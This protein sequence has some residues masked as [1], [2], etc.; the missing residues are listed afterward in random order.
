MGVV[1]KNAVGSRPN[2]PLFFHNRGVPIRTWTK[3]DNFP[4][5]N[6]CE[7][8]QHIFEQVV[9]QPL[10][11]PSSQKCPVCLV[12]MLVALPTVTLL[13]KIVSPAQLVVKGSRPAGPRGPILANQ[14]LCPIIGYHAGRLQHK[15]P[16]DGFQ[17]T[18]QHDMV[19]EGR[20][21]TVQTPIGQMK[22]VVQ[23]SQW[24]NVTIQNQHPL[25]FNHAVRI[26]FVEKVGVH[27]GGKAGLLLRQVSNLNVHGV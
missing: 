7:I 16:I 12:C 25:V 9:L 27:A 4:R 18:R 2:L 23:R 1:G 14:P 11:R 24:K 20:R 15:S 6:L 8:S 10:I 13:G 17:N 5:Q 3:I 26:K 19:F 21:L 22:H